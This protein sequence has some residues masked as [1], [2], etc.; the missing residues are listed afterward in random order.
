MIVRRRF[1]ERL[2]LAAALLALLSGAHGCDRRAPEPPAA[3]VPAS[4][5]DTGPRAGEFP[6]AER[7]AEKG[8]DIFKQK[9]CTACHAFGRL[10]TGPDL[11]GVSARRSAR[12]M[13]MQI[14]HPDIMVQEDPLTIDLYNTYLVR[15]ANQGLTLEEARC[16][17]EFLKWVDEDST[18][19]PPLPP[20]T[21]I[22]GA[23]PTAAA[24][25]PAPQQPPQA[26]AAPPETPR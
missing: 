26:P 23:P 2:G 6:V 22:G 14:L 19:A 17:I 25:E 10:L 16:V 7:L 8:R 20:S 5:Y 1:L 21:P 15:M 9:G 3:A 4:P 13:E 11:R 18:K 12:W 24:S